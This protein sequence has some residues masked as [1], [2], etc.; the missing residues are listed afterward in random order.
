[1][2]ISNHVLAGAIV[3]SRLRP[4]PALV[5][6]FVS[7]LAMDSLPHWGCVGDFPISVAKRDG[8]LGLGI[9]AACVVYAEKRDRL[10]V[11]A[12]I[13]GACMPDTDK[14]GRH[15]AGRSPWPSRFD[16]FHARIQREAAHRLPHEVVSGF[17]L[18]SLVRLALR[19]G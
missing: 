18:A 19:R 7:H 2:F 17:G 5:A 9:I 15:F 4:G 13:T 3:G 6:G 8:I 1:M 11:L 12:G 16:D 10:G 14:I